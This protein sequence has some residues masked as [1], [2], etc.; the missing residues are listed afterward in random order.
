MTKMK[1]FFF[2]SLLIF[3]VAHAQPTT[4]TKEIYLT[5]ALVTELALNQGYRTKEVNL[6]YQTYRFN[7]AQ[8]LSGYDWSVGVDFGYQYDKSVGLLTSGTTPLVNK[9]EQY[10]TILTLNKPFTTGTLLG[11]QVNRV[12]QKSDLD[13]VITLPPPNNQINDSAGILIEQSLWQNF[14]GNADHATV[15]AANDTYEA[16]KILRANDLENVVLEAIRQYW[17]T[18]AAQESLKEAIVSRDRYKKLVTAVQ[19]KTSLGYSN[20]GDLPQ[21]QAEFE[22][23]EQAVKSASTFYANNLTTLI[24]LLNLDPATTEIK[25]DSSTQLPALPNLPPKKTDELRAVR[26]QKLKVEAAKENLDASKSKSHPTLNLVG[27]AYTTGWG[28]NTKDSTS[29]L[30]SADRPKYYIGLKFR[31]NFGSDIQTEDINNKKINK[32]LEEARLNLQ[33]LTAQ[34]SQSQ[35]ERRAQETYALAVSSQ[36]QKDFR[37]KA[38]Q[39]LNRSYAQ[40]RTDISI[41]ITA[42][43]NFVA[44]EVQLIQAIGNYH[45]ALNEWSATRD[46]LIPDAP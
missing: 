37:E 40:G 30:T 21:A 2:V 42:M 11:V 13:P 1:L 33:T 6:Q 23:R 8:T 19:R 16:Q 17:T 14:F 34:D 46:E 15:K 43:N 10:K 35:A 45:I 38:A 18:Y 28:E 3:S 12:S 20:P 36:K 32:D 44:A 4:S 7:V 24:T 39:E 25:F 5:Q 27:Q 22:T 41:L 31:Y 26:S 9:Y 29:Q